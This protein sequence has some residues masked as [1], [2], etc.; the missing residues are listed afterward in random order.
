MKKK[1][2]QKNNIKD[3]RYN[4]EK[5]L[6]LNTKLSTNNNTYENSNSNNTNSLYYKEIKNNKKVN[7]NTIEE[8]HINFVNILQNSK[9]MIELQENSIRDKILYNNIHSTTIIIEERDIE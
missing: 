2:N 3:K 6:N 4:F 7:S 1:K 9:N 8:V 5:N